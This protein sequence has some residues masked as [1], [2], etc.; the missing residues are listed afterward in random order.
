MTQEA[1]QQCPPEGRSANR[2]LTD[3][4][5]AN[6]RVAL[7]RFISGQ[8]VEENLHIKCLQPQENGIWT[9]R[10]VEQPQVRLFGWFGSRDVFIV[11]H[12]EKRNQLQRGKQGSRTFAAAI[13]KAMKK[14]DETFTSLPWLNFT[15]LHAC[16]SNGV[17][18]E[19]EDDI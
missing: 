1:W 13:G 14:R 16:L 15:Y 4:V 18:D 9:L 17:S 2:H 5:L 19:P 10:V 11:S 3:D 6:T 12:I 7:E 8:E